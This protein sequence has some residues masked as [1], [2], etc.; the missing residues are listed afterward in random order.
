MK[1]TPRDQLVQRI[2]EIVLRDTA[3]PLSDAGAAEIDGVLRHLDGES[4]PS[5]FGQEF[6]SREVT[7]L[8][9]DL[10]G[11]TAIAAA[12][13]PEVV[14]A[15]LN[16]CLI[17]MSEIIYRH[18]G[19]IDKFMGDSIMVLFGAPVSSED[20]VAR[21]LACAVE[22]QTAMST[23]NLAHKDRGMPELFMGIG[24]NT[25]EVLAGMLGSERYSE[26]TVIGDEVNLASRI[27]AFS[28]RG[29]VLI[30]QSTYERCKD[31]VETSDTMDIHVKGKPQPVS[32]RELV[33]IPSLGLKVPRQEIRR[34]HRVE[35]K[36]AFTYQRIQ[37]G[38]VLPEVRTGGIRDIGYHGVLVE[39]EEDLPNFSEVKLSFELP[40]VEYQVRD[41]YAKVVGK[42]S[43]DGRT[44]LGVEFTSIPPEANLK[45]QLFVQLLIFTDLN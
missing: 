18:K 20:D 10:R 14:I 15:L 26:Y 19:T 31:F 32:L 22:M 3:K 35:V 37:H 45:I 8:L 44:Q 21:A 41:V 30:S 1:L 5:A 39:V 24:I 2:R 28:L 40:L 12:H 7:I 16:P 11:F 43:K 17:K 4:Y 36:L 25:G 34:S 29:Q 38:I 27:E 6:L 42:K 13:P 23:L 9:A 33:A